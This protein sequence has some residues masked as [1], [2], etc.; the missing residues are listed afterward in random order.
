VAGLAH[1]LVHE[2]YPGHHVFNLLLEDRL[3]R[4]RG[5]VELTVYPLWSP[6]SL[7]AEGTADAAWDTIFPGEEGR[8]FLR[9][10]V[11]PLA[12]FTDREALESYL[13]ASE[14]MEDLRGVRPLAARMLLDEGRP[15]DEVRSFLMRYGLQDREHADRAIAFIREYRAYVF[16]YAVGTELIE[17]AVGTGPDRAGRFFAILQ[18]AA[19]PGELAG[20]TPPP[21]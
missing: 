8:V 11:A 19:T 18:R 4:K 1:T 13:A 10:T 14:A 15:E 5:F 3:V 9:D 16:T 2:G 21:G 12:G 17:H 7:I 6:Q 20:R